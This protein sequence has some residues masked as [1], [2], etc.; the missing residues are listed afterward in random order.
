MIDDRFRRLV[1]GLHLVILFKNARTIDLLCLID[2]CLLLIALVVRLLACDSDESDL[3]NAYYR[4]ARLTVI[5]RYK[6]Q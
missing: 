1:F 3:D 5:S 4:R 6:S 2:Y